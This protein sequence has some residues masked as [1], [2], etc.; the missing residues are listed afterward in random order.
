M[1]SIYWR[2]GWAWGKA[3]R[4]KK[5]LR[6]PLKTRDEATA[7]IRLDAWIKELDEPAAL[8]GSGEQTV[9]QAIDKFTTDHLPTL[10]PG[11][12]R[13]YYTSARWVLEHFGEMRLREVRS[14]H[15]YSF[16]KWR[17]KMRNR[18]KRVSIVTIKRD[19]AF[20]SSVFSEAE[21]WEWHDRNPVKPYI[22]GRASKGVMVESEGRER[23]LSHEEEAKLLAAEPSDVA[24]ADLDMMV[25]AIKIAIDTGMRAEEQWT[26]A[27]EHFNFARRRVYVGADDAKGGR[28]RWIPLMPRSAE[29]VE[30]FR[31]TNYPLLCWRYEGEKIEHTWAYRIFQKMVKAAGLEDLEWHD[32]RRT[33]GCR[34]LQDHKMSME[35]VSR[36]LGHSSVKVTEKH[37]AFLRIE[38]LEAAMN[39]LPPPVDEPKNA[40]LG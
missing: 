29:I 20:L 23:Y 5:P 25:K 32:L 10:R 39:Q 1:A 21:T 28:S 40:N 3:Q 18:G 14:K 13:R 34:L 35:R 27:R 36:W 31:V 30:R 26:R 38:D 4:N 7:R 17:G 12:I 22:R 2:N 19:L 37:Y 24:P 8:G 11:G 15:L 16:E 6:R 33:C 9:R